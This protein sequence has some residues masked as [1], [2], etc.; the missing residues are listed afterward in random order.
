M[1][2]LRNRLA[3]GYASVDHE[4]L[5]NELPQGLDAL[6]RLVDAVALFTERQSQT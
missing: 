1:T 6:Q 4:R 5:W 2:A 3:H